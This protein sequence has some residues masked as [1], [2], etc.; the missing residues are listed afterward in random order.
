MVTHPNDPTGLALI[1]GS[2]N[3]RQ[4]L[5]IVLALGTIVFF[6]DTASAKRISLKDGQNVIN[7]CSGTTW[8]PG[9]TGH[10][11]G[12]IMSDGSGVVCGGVT[13]EQ[14]STCDTFRVTRSNL[15][16]IAARGAMPA[17]RRHKRSTRY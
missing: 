4:P 17:A 2:L 6:A 12:C 14:Q 7:H 13:S 3:V 11:S 16:S 1:G 9:S 5:A 15:R 8:V 10:T